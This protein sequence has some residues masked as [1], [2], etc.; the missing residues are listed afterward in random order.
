MPVTENDKA[1]LNFFS[2]VQE[3]AA[4]CGKVF[5]FWSFEGNDIFTDDLDG[6]DM[7]GWLV[8]LERSAE[9]EAAW[10]ASDQLIPDDLY[11]GFVIARWSG[12]P[13]DGIH[14]KFE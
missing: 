1:R 5:Y 10:K 11:D 13:E 8:P 9:F 14:I 2:I 12:S 7:S 6:G 4:A 3:A